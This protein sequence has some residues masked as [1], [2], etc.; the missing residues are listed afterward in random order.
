MTSDE[1]IGKN[2]IQDIRWL[3]SLSESELDLL[4]SLKKMAI[5]RSSFIEHHFLSHKFD[6][7]LLRG[8]SFVLIQVL[9]DR[10]GDN[11]QVAE[12]CLE[13]SNLVKQEISEEFREMGVEELMACIG[14]DRKKVISEFLGDDDL[15]VEKKR[16]LRRGRTP[17]L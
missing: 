7:K 14:T 10:L 5:Q 1:M 9:K 4:I 16:F 12:S 6:L 11:S 17:L 2:R 15:V 3:C 13:K 8:L